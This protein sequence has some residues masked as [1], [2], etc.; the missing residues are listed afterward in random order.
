MLKNKIYTLFTLIFTAALLVTA[1]GGNA[2]NEAIIQTSVAET[3]AAQASTEPPVTDTPATTL[4][5]SRT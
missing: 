1:C 3:V 5:P 4:V 2:D